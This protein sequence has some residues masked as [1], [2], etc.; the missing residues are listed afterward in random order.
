MFLGIRQMAFR[1]VGAS[2]DVR[3]NSNMAKKKKEA[4]DIKR[5]FAKALKEREG[6]A[7]YIRPKVEHK[8]KQTHDEQGRELFNVAEGCPSPNGAFAFGSK[9]GKK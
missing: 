2:A 1:N 6:E 7:P 8:G 5:A 3:E 4:F 9:F